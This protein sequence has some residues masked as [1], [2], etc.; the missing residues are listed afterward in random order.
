MNRLVIIG[1]GDF[2]KQV[3]EIAL[4][5]NKYEVIGFYDD[6]ENEKAIY[7]YDVLGKVSNVQEDYLKGK[8][9]FI[10][11]GI[12]YNHLKFKH[13]LSLQLKIPKATIIHPTAVIEESAIIGEGCAIYANVYIGPNV[14]LNENV[15]INV[16]ANLPHDNKVEDC[17]FISVNVT[18]GGKT[19][20][21]NCCFL[22]LSSTVI[23]NVNLSD[24][25]FLG[26][27]T[28]VLKDIGSE[29]TYIGSPAKKLH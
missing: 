18:L 21:G 16:G 15:T 17:T 24:G 3:L 4:L 27:G 23:E 10:F 25:V 14:I 9:D 1:S 8:F 29:G 12:G 20:I 19:T 13:D 26:A 7:S 28:L 2:G 5:Q 6:F 22:G 11:F